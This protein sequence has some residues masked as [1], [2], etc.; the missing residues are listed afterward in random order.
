MT[1]DRLQRIQRE[2]FLAAF[3]ARLDELPSWVVDR[4]T[5]ILDERQVRAGEVLWRAGE[6]LELIYFML[7]GRVRMTREGAPPWTF[8]GRWFLGGFDG[9]LDVSPRTAV[10]DSDFHAM[11]MPRRAWLDLLEDS[12]ELTS[13]GV[14]VSSSAVARLEE[15]VPIEATGPARSRTARR[16]MQLDTLARLTLLTE[17]ELARGAG[18]QA[19]ADLAAVSHPMSL[20]AG[21]T[22]FRAEDPRTH[23]YLVVEG[24]L[25][26]TRR[27]P[28][29]TRVHR[30]GEIVGGAAAFSQRI[31][32]WE[33]RARTPATLLAIPLE[34][35]FDLMEE[36]FG[37]ARSLMRQ[38][39]VW[40]ERALDQL[41]LA[42]GPGGL[43]LT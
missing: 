8:E 42:A 26:G 33:A 12:F 1:D 35:W 29:L 24:E 5:L 36:H 15:Q 41:A 17:L 7:R 2:L 14:V 23:L 37:L 22:L 3:G 16:P 25:T 38:L 32:A 39:A 27:T 13:S 6:P 19:L 11:A 21:E 10:A 43:E 34:A 4:L 18:V 9:H 40:R 28:D 31:L 20:V 30:A